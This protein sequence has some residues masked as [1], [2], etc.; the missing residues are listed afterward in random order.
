MRFA[1]IVT[2]S[3]VGAVLTSPTAKRALAG[4]VKYCMD[5]NFGGDCLKVSQFNAT[6]CVGIGKGFND[7]ISSFAPDKGLKCTIWSDFDCQG[8]GF[9]Y[10]T[11]PGVADLRTSGWNDVISSF[12]CIAA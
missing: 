4:S 9:R 6:Q 10:I 2:L 12:E 3:V 5:I 1:S 11:N 8:T 7:Q